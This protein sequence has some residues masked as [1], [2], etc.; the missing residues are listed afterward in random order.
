MCPA[1]ASPARASQR[2]RAER[3]LPCG[4][5]PRASPRRPLTRTGARLPDL[6]QEDDDGRQV[7][8]VPSQPEDVHGGG[9]RSGGPEARQRLRTR[10][11]P[12]REEAAKDG[13]SGRDVARDVAELPSRA[14]GSLGEQA[15][16][17]PRPLPRPLKAPS[18]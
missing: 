7:G 15:P 5:A 10:R 14:R 13:G 8:Q 1:I 16:A 6:Q 4:P 17:G 18:P 2:P 3:V 11:Q 9:S 12:L